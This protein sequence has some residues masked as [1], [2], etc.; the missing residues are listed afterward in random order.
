MDVRSEKQMAS[1][2]VNT[3]CFINLKMRVNLNTCT[4]VEHTT[5]RAVGTGGC[6]PPHL[7][8]GRNVNPIPI[9]RDWA[10]QYFR[11]DNVRMYL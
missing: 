6:P 2:N 1:L 10:D 5:Y 7:D 9:M 11:S 8:F 3:V 4:Y